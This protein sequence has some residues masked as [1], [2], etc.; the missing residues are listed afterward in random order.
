MIGMRWPSRILCTG[1]AA[2]WFAGS[3][4]QAI[5]REQLRQLAETAAADVD[6]EAAFYGAMLAVNTGMRGGEVKKLRTGMVD[7]EH[8]RL[9]IRRKD[10]KSDA[11]ARTIELNHDATEAATRLLLRAQ[12]IG[13]TLPEHYLFP[14]CL[15]RIQHGAEKGKRGYDPVQHQTSWRTAWRS[16]TKKA[17]LATLRFH[18]LRH[19]F[20]SHMIERG[21]PIG[22]VQ[23]MVGHISAKMLRH[24]TH[25]ST[26]VAR[27]A[28]EQLDAEPLLVG[29]AD[30]AQMAAI[31]RLQ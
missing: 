6:W 3:V 2:F 26:G 20:I 11:S 9:R 7:L 24:Y 1:H 19:S 18:D 28:V 25:V 22:V 13:A 4:G 31:G 29:A 8:R 5:T 16:L 10:A 14:K 23:N 27:K 30:V 12:T 21:I 15:S 17:G